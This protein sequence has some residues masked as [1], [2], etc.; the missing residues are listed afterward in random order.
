[1]QEARSA[2]PFPISETH[3][4]PLQHTHTHT[5]GASQIPPQPPLKRSPHSH[6]ASSRLS[7][8]L[9]VS[10]QTI[11]QDAKQYAQ[12]VGDWDYL[13]AFSET[14]ERVKDLIYAFTLRLNFVVRT[15]LERA[16][17][18]IAAGNSPQMGDIHVR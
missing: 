18:A 2:P 17:M 14:H 8:L 15:L 13:K 4:P 12:L 9:C 7:A 1:M 3:L 6:P 16:R 5:C 11:T 10:K